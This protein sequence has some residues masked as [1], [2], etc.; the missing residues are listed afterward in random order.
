VLVEKL[1][2]GGF[3]QVWKARDDNG[4]EVALKFLR[5]DGRAGATELR[6][7]EVMKN[8]RHA[9]VVPMFRSWQVG[10]W[11]VFALELGDKTLYHRLAEAEKQGHAGIPRP[12]LL[13]YLLDAARGLDYLHTLNIQHR[14]VKPQN[15]LLVG[16][17][18]KVADFGLAKLLEH[19]LA[20]NSG[21][22]TVAYAAPEQFQ[23]L[24]S[25]HSDQYSL[26][27]SYCQLC[28][29]GLPFRG[30]QHEIMFGHVQRQPDLSGLSA[31]DR[32]V[33]AKALSKQPD[34][35]WPSCR[36]F[37][38][39]LPGTATARAAAVPPPTLP[40]PT[41]PTTTVYPKRRS[42]LYA[43]IGSVVFPA[44]VVGVIVSLLTPEP[45]VPTPTTKSAQAVTTPPETG[46]QLADTGKRLNPV[47]KVPPRPPVPGDVRQ[48]P[49]LLDCTGEA[50]VSD[51]DMKKAQQAWA[52]YLGRKVEEEVEIADGVR[53]TFV[54]VPPGKFRMG[55][56]DGEA[57][58]D[59]TDET[60]HTVELT[61][62][63][64]LG[65]YE[66]TQA[67]FRAL[68]KR[69]NSE[70]L[71]DPDPSKFKP[72]KGEDLPVE[73]VS[74]DEAD[75]FGQELT[76]LRADKHVY[77]LPTEAEWEY[78]CRAGRPSSQPFGIGD[79]RS[80]SSLQA[81]FYDKFLAQTTKV[82]TSDPNALG[83][84]DM[85]GNV[86][87]WCHDWYGSYYGEEVTNPEGPSKSPDR[88]FRGGSW[89][90]RDKNCRAA[91]RGRNVPSLRS[92]NLGFR[93]ARSV[94]SGG[95]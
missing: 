31:E 39:A 76:N 51:A 86:W 41:L 46:Q 33:V 73:Q 91:G 44:L 21:G 57:D 12:E 32:P 82:G 8:V 68:V 42:R 70:K 36:A 48:G 19:S 65:K 22:L 26:A 5:L 72:E 92:S 28:G 34:Q 4:F 54:L 10:G 64:D 1:G 85:H 52:Q 90:D 83:L 53:M 9:H 60:L 84:Y 75:A 87:E 25:P 27:V 30:G 49:A 6:A 14:D 3:G 94:P 67:Q 78:G 47:S 11:F 35:R 63:F 74:W 50:G 37:V 2:E 17:T 55:S 13:E 95:K 81:N 62:P 61:E 40:P 38:E 29:A 20:S 16:G 71:K 88:V 56:P 43:V 18:V 23:G 79:G 59:K 45:A 93:L 80:L 24:V 7:L 15:L 58:R 66:V 89:S 69:A 77:R